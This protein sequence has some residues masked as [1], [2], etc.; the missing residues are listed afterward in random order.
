MLERAQ[1]RGCLSTTFLTLFSTLRPVV[2]ELGH[3]GSGGIVKV[4]RQSDL[5]SLRLY[6]VAKVLCHVCESQHCEATESRW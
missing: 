1:G 6:F 2:L 3:S 5:H 4:T